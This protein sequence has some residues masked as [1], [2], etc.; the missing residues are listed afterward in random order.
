MSIK[1]V[2]LWRIYLAFAMIALMGVAVLLQAFRIQTIEGPYWRNMADS[3]TTAYLS[4]EA[5]RGNIYSEDGRLLATLLPYFEIRMDM[6]TETMT[7]KIFYDNVDSLALCM[8]DYFKN[9]GREEY[10]ETLVKARRS[11]KRYLL[12][13]KK[14]SYPDLQVMKEWP[15]FR[16]G[17]YKGGL[18]IV[19]KNK[20]VNPFQM[21]A[22]RTIGYVR[23]NVQPVGLEGTFNNLLSGTEGKRLMQRIGGEA[24]I[25][26]NEDDE[27]EPKNGLDI[28]T[29]IDVNLQDVAEHALLKTLQ[30]HRADHGCVV[31]M[32]V[33]TGKIKAIA[34]LG[35]VA[36]D[37]YWETYNYA[38]GEAT[39]PGS[40]FKLASIL[41]LLKDG[42]I[43]IN[44]S[45]DLQ[46]G[47]KRYFDKEMQDA[48]EHDYRR[49][50]VKR[51]FE[52]SS[53]VGIS[54]L[55][56]EH[57]TGKAE[58]FVSHLRS[59][60]LDKKTGIEIEG[61]PAP[62]INSPG[63]KNWSGTTLP[64][65]AV[66][67]EIQLTPLQLLTFYNAIA[68]NG[69]IV[70]PYLVSEI[71]EY[72]NTVKKF[73]P[74]VI[75]SHIASQ[76]VLSQLRSLLEG[77]VENGTAKNIR[78]ENYRIAGKTGTS[79]IAD[80]K[81][82]YKQVYQASFAGYFPADKPLYSCIVVINAPAAG[83]YYGGYV[84]APIFREIADKVYAA[85][86][87]MH[88]PVNVQ[89]IYYT[90]NIPLA[91]NGY[92]DDIRY[93]YNELGIS[94]G[95]DTEKD[96]VYCSRKDYSID[97]KERKII[98]GLTPDVTGMGLRDALYLLENSGLNVQIS[99]KGRVSYQ[100]MKP[101]TK[102]VKGDVIT[103]E[104]S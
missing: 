97:L 67:Y 83:V 55:V 31:V 104:L 44:D 41:A 21:L 30:K 86:T 98:D 19:Q 35:K 71:Q 80:K 22:H 43:D 28:I 73:E 96:W 37:E 101:G 78:T 5:D 68:N 24:W 54:S 90:S 88:T 20:R 63:Q 92:S 87:S 9:A 76:N 60:N 46:G 77:V 12:I 81:H 39:E 1:K 52:I 59:M 89:D 95:A 65:M 7:D 51:A 25:P 16:L 61:E 11:G 62:F 42:M 64:W 15:L 66:G 13:R 36:G 53:N 14:I 103:I 26:V 27:I 48:E 29:T 100:S 70:K 17:R 72:G 23:D 18:I 34:N 85:N 2:I 40:T 79:K 74:V 94:N 57:Y 3:L 69:I 99:G 45:V 8:A 38:V 32:E 102:A 6:R 82:G 93:I 33:A 47:G 49:M 75:N 4:I 84:A 10:M 50:S 91:K 58:V 56:Y